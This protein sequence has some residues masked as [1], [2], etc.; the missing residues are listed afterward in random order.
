[1]KPAQHLVAYRDAR[2]QQTLFFGPFVSSTIADQFRDDLPEPLEGGCSRIVSLQ[3][4]TM[5]EASVVSQKILSER[6]PA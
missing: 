4:F 5:H 6:Q 1:M 2:G 3:P